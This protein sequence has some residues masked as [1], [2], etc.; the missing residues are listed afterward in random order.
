VLKKNINI[1]INLLVI[2]LLL[3]I[4]LGQHQHYKEFEEPEEEAE[5]VC[6]KEL[7][8]EYQ[9]DTIY[10]QK[11]SYKKFKKKLNSNN[12]I[13]IAI[14]DSTSSTNNKFLELVNRTSY[15]TNE[16]IYVLDISKLSKK[17]TIEF[18]EIDE[19]LSNLEYNYIM[20][21]KNNIIYS[22]TEYNQEEL[23]TLIEEVGD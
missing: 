10:Y 12:L 19:R 20:K 16:I 21:I 15:T 9:E 17:N 5:I 3:V 22:L 18:Y 11:L 13:T 23:N 4:I 7:Q 8:E 6:P 1:I 14:I 2:T